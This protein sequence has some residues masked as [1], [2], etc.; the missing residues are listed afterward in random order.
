MKYSA[1]PPCLKPGLTNRECIFIIFGCCLLTAFVVFVSLM[2]THGIL[3]TD[4][5][6]TRF[7][8]IL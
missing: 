7:F 8:R 5:L 6:I 3:K 1:L 4:D 2:N